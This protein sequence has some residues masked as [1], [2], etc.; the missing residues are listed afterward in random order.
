MFPCSQASRQPMYDLIPNRHIGSKPRHIQ[1]LPGGADSSWHQN[2][3]VLPVWEM[4]DIEKTM[5]KS[6]ENHNASTIYGGPAC[7]MTIGC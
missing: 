6:K 4:T 2:F 3:N 5:G 7:K 1:T